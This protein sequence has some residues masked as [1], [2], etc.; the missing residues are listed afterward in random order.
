MRFG[1]FGGAK[2]VGTGPDADSHGY[3]QFI[4]YVLRAEELGFGNLFMVEHHFTGVGQVSAS[5]NLLSFLAARTSRMRLG[6]AVVVLPWHNPVLLAEQVATL[7]LLSGGRFDFGIGKGYRKSE[8]QGFAIPQAEADERF[9]EALTVLRLAWTSPGRFSHQGARW[10]FD[11][12][13]VEPR[14]VQLPHPPLWMAA[15][16]FESIRRAGTRGFNLLLDQIAPVDLTLERVAHYRAALEAAGR[17]RQGGQVALARALQIA[18]TAE[19]RAE[20]RQVR[21][22]VLQRIGDL[23][24]GP[25][26]ERYHN[27]TSLA[28]A[29]LAGDDA[30]LIG[31]PEEIAARLDRLAAGGV[32]MVLLTDPNGSVKNLERFQREIVPR[33]YFGGTILN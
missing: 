11:N 12:V 20:A 31:T 10:R 13:V 9:E 8:F 6:T 17:G 18:S 7:D 25:G 23:A 4:D 24:R 19:E 1:L 5:L 3:R 14:P 30:A 28:D 16:S 2:S 26:A 29:D 21:R 15:G 27:A 32:D 22:R 33:L